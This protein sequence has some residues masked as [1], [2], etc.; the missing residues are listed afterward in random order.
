MRIGVDVGGTRVEAIALDET[1]R[2]LLRRGTPTGQGDYDATV[3]AIAGLVHAFEEELSLHGT[4]GV[5]IPGTVSP[6]SGLVKNARRAWLDGRPLER[7]LTDRL[8]RTVR[9]AT[10]A[11]CFTLS[12]AR[13]G[14]GL[15]TRVVFGVLLGP[16]CRGGLVVDGRLIAGA[17][18]IAG[19][20]GH[21]PLPWPE[22]QEWPG[23]P[24]H[25]GRRGC[26]ET[27]LSESG[28]TGDHR[29]VTGA[30][31]EAPDILA[32]AEAGDAAALA[33]L[34]R[35]EHRLARALAG[36]VNVL[37]P[38]VIVLGGRLASSSRLGEEVSQIWGRFA[39]SDKLVNRLRSPLHG[40]SSGVRGAAFL[41]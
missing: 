6:A 27:F 16:G 30:I 21:N 13:D 28:L 25:C 20:W 26:I 10:D 37:D 32:R 29:E 38:D 36:L 18:A 3:G 12:E 5:A 39:F 4:V 35:Y 19:E 7:D 40:E 24:C 15:G 22:G 23:L 14:A 8:E 11:G 33:T 31:L 41:W 2:V 1:G 9:L 17:N 34:T